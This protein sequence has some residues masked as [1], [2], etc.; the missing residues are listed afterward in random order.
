MVNIVYVSSVNT[1]V[2]SLSGFGGGY[3]RDMFK[4]YQD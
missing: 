2:K 1:L 4:K 3:Q